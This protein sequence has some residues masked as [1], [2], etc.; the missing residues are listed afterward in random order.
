MNNKIEKYYQQ[1]LKN[2]RTLNMDFYEFLS[3]KLNCSE[4]TALRTIKKW[5]EQKL[6]NII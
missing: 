4:R 2:H 6:I 5:K 3:D 1:Y